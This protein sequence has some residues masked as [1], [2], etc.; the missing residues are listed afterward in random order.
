[1]SA[2][3]LAYDQAPPFGVPLACFRLAALFLFVAAAVALLAL[4]DWLASRWSAPALALT[5]LLTLGFLGL[6]MLGALVQMVPVLLG[7]PLPA[8]ARVTGLARWSLA[9]ATPLLAAGFISGNAGALQAAMLILGLGLLPFGLALTSVL[10][11]A[12]SLPWLAWP[13]RLAGFAFALT[14]LL[15]LLLTGWLAGAWPLADPLVWTARHVAWGLLGGVAMLIVGVAYQVVPMLQVTPDYPAR[16]RPVFTGLLFVGVVAYSLAPAAAGG[17]L[18]LPALLALLGFAG[19][20]LRLQARRR[21]KRSDTTHAFWRFGMSALIVSVLGWLALPWLPEVAELS[22]GILFLLGFAAAVVHG[23]LYKIVPFLA[24]FH[25]QAQTGAKAGS[26]PNMTQMIDEAA[27]RRHYLS[28]AWATGLLVL[29][30]CLPGGW[31]SV[32]S[33]S[34]AVL[35]GAGALI[36]AVNLTGA[37]RQFLRHGGRL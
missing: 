20:T 15:G 24:W 11:R 12:R 6:V 30:P 36:L 25:L 23:M 32:V 5:H 14:V 26:I 1:M 28:H 35:L 27:M 8:A 29:A 34:G 2:S 10:L 4:P 22:V 18:A 19:M 9:L 21:R 3:G 7:L 33:G 37:R 13:L 17:S 31:A 16:L